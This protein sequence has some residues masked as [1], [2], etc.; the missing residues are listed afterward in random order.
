M[1]NLFRS[2]FPRQTATFFAAMIGLIIATTAI[3]IFAVP[4]AGC[5]GT[6]ARQNIGIPAAVL[7]LDGFVEDAKVGVET[8]PPAQQA[9]AQADLI[10]FESAVRSNN[11][12]T[13]QTEA[14]TRWQ[15]VKA[16]ALS[17]IARREEIGTIGPNGAVLLRERVNRLGELL[18]KLVPK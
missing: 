5:A 16:M 15:T 2:V 8:L 17:G 18:P 10:A 1:F 14:S 6:K 13:I 4:M 9:Q 7:A 3:G 11:L 12:L